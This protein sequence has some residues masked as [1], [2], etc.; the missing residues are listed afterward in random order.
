MP[1]TSSDISLLIQN[2][3]AAFGNAA[4]YAQQ[5]GMQAG[6]VPMGPP[7]PTYNQ[8]NISD[9]RNAPLPGFAAPA[10]Q[11]GAGIGAGVIGA[12]IASMGMASLGADLLGTTV[13]GMRSW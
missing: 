13:G 3:Q 11:T 8:V 5:I 1:M 12:G 7:A 6:T 10:A 4:A 2:Q 9:P